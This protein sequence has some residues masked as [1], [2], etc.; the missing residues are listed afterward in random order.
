MVPAVRA[1]WPAGNG[2]VRLAAL[3]AIVNQPTHCPDLA[4]SCSVSTVSAVPVGRHCVSLEAEAE[5]LRTPWPPPRHLVPGRSCRWAGGA[6][7]TLLEAVMTFFVL[8]C[9]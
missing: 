6:A 2:S 7:S 9:V 1:R 3:A 5:E 4:A 8:G